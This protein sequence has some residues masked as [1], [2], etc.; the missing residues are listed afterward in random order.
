MLYSLDV[1]KLRFLGRVF[2]THICLI[3]SIFGTPFSWLGLVWF[4]K[5][6]PPFSKGMVDGTR[7]HSLSLSF[8][9]L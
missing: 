1:T 8:L 2:P 5:L 4:P 3:I 7:D 6:V 9:P